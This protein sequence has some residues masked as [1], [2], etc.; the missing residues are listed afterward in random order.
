MFLWHCS[1]N[2]SSKVCSSQCQ[3]SKIKKTWYSRSVIGF[4]LIW[5]VKLQRYR[6]YFCSAWKKSQGSGYRAAS[7]VVHM[8]ERIETVSYILLFCLKYSE[9]FLCMRI[10]WNSSGKSDH[11]KFGTFLLFVR[12]PHESS[13]LG[14][15][16]KRQW[17]GFHRSNL[18]SHQAVSSNLKNTWIFILIFGHCLS[19]L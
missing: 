15:V 3:S 2:Y 7:S 18:Y 19:I 6:K 17:D 9:L 8:K 10:L 1:L 11:L 12:H 14:M 13:F 5:R 4:T 16:F